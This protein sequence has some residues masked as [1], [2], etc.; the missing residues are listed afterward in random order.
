MFGSTIPRDRK[1]KTYMLGKV[2]DDG[3]FF[4]MSTRVATGKMTVWGSDSKRRGASTFVNQYGHRGLYR[5]S[6]EI[7]GGPSV[8]CYLGLYSRRV[9]ERDHSTQHKAVW[10]AI[11]RGTR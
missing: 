3:G 11:V 6:A 9:E 5:R 8:A 10:P 2:E 1:N 7:T 4:Q